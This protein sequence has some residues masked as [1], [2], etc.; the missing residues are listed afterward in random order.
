MVYCDGRKKYCYVCGQYW[1]ATSNMDNFSE[2]LHKAYKKCYGLSAKQNE[3]TPDTCCKNCAKDLRRRASNPEASIRMQIPVLWGDPPEHQ[4]AECYFCVNNPQQGMATRKRAQH[5]SMKSTRYVEHP[6]DPMASN[7]DVA[8]AGSMNMVPE[9]VAAH[10]NTNAVASCSYTV[11]PDVA[12]HSSLSSPEYASHTPLNPVVNLMRDRQGTVETS[13]K[14]SFFFTSSSNQLEIF[15][16]NT[17]T[18]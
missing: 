15:K 8:V 9:P 5:R 12:P 14:F 17:H 13:G 3:T 1:P 2:N 16:I 18:I 11:S 10:S 6:R 4:V 7:A